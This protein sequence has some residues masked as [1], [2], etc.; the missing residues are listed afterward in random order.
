M[1]SDAEFIR[2]IAFLHPNGAS[3][4]RHAL[5]AGMRPEWMY[6]VMLATPNEDPALLFKNEGQHW[7]FRPEGLV[8]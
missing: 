8:A 6:A 5:A 4:A 3:A 7:T 2:A 1:I